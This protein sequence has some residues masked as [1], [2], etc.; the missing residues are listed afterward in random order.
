MN[1]KECGINYWAILIGINFY[2]G[3]PLKGAVQDVQA[4]KGYLES[5]PVEGTPVNISTF[6][7]TSPSGEDAHHLPVEAP[8]NWPTY[9]N[10]MS[11]LAQVGDMAR[12]GDVVYIHY[13]GHGTRRPSPGSGDKHEDGGE[14]AGDVA[15]VLLSDNPSRLRYLA[16]RE[17]AHQ[18][19]EMVEHGLHV[20]LVLDCC[21]SGSVVRH[22]SLNSSSIRTIEYDPAI[23]LMPVKNLRSQESHACRPNTSP[24]RNSRL[25]P[26]WLINPD[27]YTILT[28]CGMH[29][30]AYELV[31]GGRQH[32]ALSFFLLQSLGQLRKTGVHIS[33]QSL[34]QHIR[35]LFHAYW[36]QQN[37]MRYG[38][39]DLSFFG[40]LM[41]R[42]T[43]PFIPVF[44][45][46]GFLRLA[47]GSAHGVLEDDRYSVY[48]F[49]TPEDGPSGSTVD[50]VVV[51]VTTVRGLTSDLV[52]VDRSDTSQVTTGW[53]AKPLTH[54]SRWKVRVGLMASVDNRVQWSTAVTQRHHFEV[55]VGVSDGQACHLY[56]AI[57][58]HGEYEILDASCNEILSLPKVP[59]DLDTAMGH[60]LHLLEHVS[61]F[62]YIE[63]IVNRSPSIPFE[64]S[65]QITLRNT[66]GHDFGTEGIL[67]VKHGDALHL[68]VQN[69]C[70]RPLYMAIFDFGPS[71][72]IASLI[73]DDG[74]GDYISI[75]SA[76]K[77]TLFPGRETIGWAMEVPDLFQQRGQD[78]CED[79]I[80]VF[81]TNQ[82]TSFA[83]MVLPKI[84]VPLDV[85]RSSPR[86]HHQLST[87]LDGLLTSFRHPQ[88]HISGEEEWT[89]RNFVIRTQRN[90]AGIDLQIQ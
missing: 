73:S 56:I 43:V 9:E 19:K 23:D 21:F 66:A 38:N 69:L 37:P 5:S 4:I 7:A 28:A 63:G 87:V 52:G 90:D 75:P 32:G 84:S 22:G 34:Y 26:Q 18:L 76:N 46:D 8:K 6:T 24:T 36:P 20:T 41:S 51:Q 48:P 86:D 61:C 68:T 12:P 65:F 60:V 71:W 58:T 79:I 10:V 53:K 30:R 74:G 25:L 62:K 29:E 45:K 14:G 33:H 77:E 3:R 16:S 27:G 47:A 54:L 80:K 82:P 64:Q 85:T 35:I 57:N 88:D 17:L 50:P 2:P 13:S 1:D 40:E 15:L 42:D 31:N 78:Q 11:S 67:D 49:E 39:Q 89:T 81:L 55:Y 59:A 83:P 72:Q 44:K 70:D